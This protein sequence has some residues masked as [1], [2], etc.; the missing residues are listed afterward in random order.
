LAGM[1]VLR[2]GPDDSLRA[3]RYNS[4]TDSRDAA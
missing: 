1:T 2:S 3:A 4:V